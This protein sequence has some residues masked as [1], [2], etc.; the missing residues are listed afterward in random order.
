MSTDFEDF[1][2]ANKDR[3]DK[4]SPQPETWRKLE[5]RLV[6]YHQK[7][8]NT[9]VIRMRLAAAASTLA[10]VGLTVLLVFERHKNF[11][12]IETAAV[13]GTDSNA[14]VFNT[15]NLRNFVDQKTMQSLVRYTSAI[16]EKQQQI[17]QLLSSNPQLYGDFVIAMHSLDQLFRELELAIANSPNRQSILQS[18]IENLQLRETILDNQL[19]LL[20]N[21]QSSNGADH[22]NQIDSF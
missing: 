19:Q 8:R 11:A 10:I 15:D 16:T 9:R 18:M 1:L 7:K 21:L 13:Q 4:G 3:L 6:A 2:D 5:Q 20:N 22:E 14:S 17:K 12:K